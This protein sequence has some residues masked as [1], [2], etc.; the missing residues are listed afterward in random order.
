M[1]EVEGGVRNPLHVEVC[2][3]CQS[4]LFEDVIFS[5]INSVAAAVTAQTQGNLALDHVVKMGRCKEHFFHLSCL[6]QQL[7]ETL[8][9]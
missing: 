4:G 3:I 1:K 7:G 8:H 6:V 2:P 5:D 9:L